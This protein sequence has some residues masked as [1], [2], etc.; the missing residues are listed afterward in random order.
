[1]EAAGARSTALVVLVVVLAGCGGGGKTYSAS[2]TRSCLEDAGATVDASGADYIAQAASGGGFEVITADR[3]ILNVSF[4]K[5]NG[6][7]KQ[8]LDSYRAL[9]GGGNP[10]VYRKGNAVLVWDDDPGADRDTVDG[11]LN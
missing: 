6:E 4:G 11:C 1:V 5:D 10:G 8:I 2:A 7:A 9:G 3:K